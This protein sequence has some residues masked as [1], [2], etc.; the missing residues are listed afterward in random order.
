[1]NHGV[2]ISRVFNPDDHTHIELVKY[3]DRS[4]AMGLLAVMAAG[5][6]PAIMRTLSSFW[7]FIS[8]PRR[9]WKVLS[10]ISRSIPSSCW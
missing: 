3:P 4:G 5:D 10:R 9:V 1:M 2:A 7:T 6:G 8:S